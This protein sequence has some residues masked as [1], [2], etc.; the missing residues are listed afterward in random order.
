MNIILYKKTKFNNK[1]IKKLRRLRGIKLCL[2]I[3]SNHFKKRIRLQFVHI[4]Y[5]IVKTYL[6]KI[7]LV[8]WKNRFWKKNIPK[9]KPFFRINSKNKKSLNERKLQKRN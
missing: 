7:V 3:N 8:N 1:W 9:N 6:H 5:L 2:K 4:K